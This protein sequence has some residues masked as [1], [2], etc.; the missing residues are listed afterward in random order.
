MSA[1]IIKGRFGRATRFAAPTSPKA[2]R[3]LSSMARGLA[4]LLHFP[5]AG[6]YN[7]AHAAVALQ[8]ESLSGRRQDAP[9]L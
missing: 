5:T 7:G 1:L 3:S 9:M 2:R 6:L 8:I 4:S